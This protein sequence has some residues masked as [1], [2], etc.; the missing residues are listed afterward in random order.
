MTK[1]RPRFSAACPSSQYK[2]AV[3]WQLGVWVFFAGV[4]LGPG[5][6][7]DVGLEILGSGSRLDV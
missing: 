5:G 1:D 4:I 3:W 2:I 6:R 7:L